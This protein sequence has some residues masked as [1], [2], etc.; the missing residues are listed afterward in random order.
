[1]S[2]EA[3]VQK[4]PELV[5]L[6]VSA[7]GTPLD[8]VQRAFGEAFGSVRYQMRNIRVSQLLDGLSTQ[9]GWD[10]P[11]TNSVGYLMDLGN[12]L[13][14]RSGL[15]AAAARLAV[16]GIQADRGEEGERPGVVTLVRSAKR[17]E[18]IDAFRDIYGSRLLVV[19][20][21]ASEKYRRETLIKRLKEEG[22]VPDGQ[23]AEGVSRHLLDRDENEAFEASGQRL[24]KAYSKADAYV[25]IRE[26]VNP[27]PEIERIVK[28][29]FGDQFGTPTRDEQ[30][31]FQAKSAQ[32]R[33][34]AAGRQVGVAIIDSDGEVLVTGTND[35]PKPGGGQYWVGDQP[36]FRDFQLSYET[37]DIGQREVVQDA[38]ER[39]R[40]AG[41]ISPEYSQVSISELTDRVLRPGGPLEDS[42][43]TDL[44]EFGRIMHA[45]MAAICTA[46]RRG[47]PLR[48][49]TLYTTTFPCHECARLIIG[50]GIGRV[51]YID[52]YPKSQVDL[53]FSHL[54]SHGEGLAGVEAVE[55]VPFQGFSPALF[56]EV[57]RMRGRSRDLRGNFE[58]SDPIPLAVWGSVPM[59]K[60]AAPGD[61]EDA[62]STAL[63]G[64]DPTTLVP[65]EGA[66]DASASTDSATTDGAEVQD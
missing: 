62:E 54:I 47:T 63:A 33:S 35:V 18:E 31:M 32:F 59:T 20:V 53:L 23:N 3:D 10:L 29:W 22:G 24:R 14:E 49:A 65:D 39:L 52:P 58:A 11:K 28:I 8:E 19:G 1:M 51:V 46:A 61:A 9:L 43:V 17:P 42:R 25:W 41:W 21:S 64:F 2:D 13:R 26:G 56:A 6:I 55:F 4:R 50:A 40:S 60:I 38:L 57:F 34:A 45:E 15:P 27:K 16:L 44:I 36:D 66:G 30:A 12:Y 48:G 7:L 5:V 37:N